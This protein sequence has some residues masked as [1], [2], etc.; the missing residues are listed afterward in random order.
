MWT[1]S[2]VEKPFSLPILRRKITSKW[3]LE[4]PQSLES[5]LIKFVNSSWIISPSRRRA[6]VERCQKVCQNVL[7]PGKSGSWKRMKTKARKDLSFLLHVW[8]FQEHAPDVF[9]G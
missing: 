3:K 1:L 2:D 8:I 9:A 4:E 6:A 5:K 7:G